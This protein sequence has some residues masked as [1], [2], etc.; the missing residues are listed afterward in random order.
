LGDFPTAKRYLD[1]FVRRS[2]GGRVA[3]AVSLSAEIDRARQLLRGMATS[4]AR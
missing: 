3:L 1:G 2:S 4:S